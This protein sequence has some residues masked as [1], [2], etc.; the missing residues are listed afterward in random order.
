GGF[1]EPPQGM[2]SAATAATFWRS[3]EFKFA[4]QGIA[5]GDV[6]GDKRTEVVLMD[7]R[8][9]CIHRL[10]DQNL[11]QLWEKAGTRGHR[12]ISVDVADV[13]GNGRAEIFLTCVKRPGDRLDSFVLEW[14]GKEFQPVSEEDQWYYRVIDSPDRGLVLLGQKRTMDAPFASGVHEL[15]WQQGEYASQGP[16]G[17]PKGVHIFGFAQGEVKNNGLQMTIAL[18]REDHLRLF[19][20]SGD[21]KWK[22]GERYGGSM[23]FV[24]SWVKNED[25]PDRLYLPQ[26]VHV[27]DLDGDGKNEVVVASNEGAMGRLFARLRKFTSGHMEILSWSSVGFVPKLQTPKLSGYISDFSIG[28]V[29]HDG[30]DE[31]VVAHVSQGGLPLI[32]GSTS[33]IISYE[34]TEKP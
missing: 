18:D 24:E 28:D 23:I 15:A 30:K 6:D 3:P 1:A 20:L 29:D 13:N 22:S 7:D 34:I 33:A 4:I 9:V 11:V 17:L 12:L 2:P 10:Q 5:L 8:R 14:D 32:G 25:T 21:E 19:S 31:V 27:G 16:F 26:R